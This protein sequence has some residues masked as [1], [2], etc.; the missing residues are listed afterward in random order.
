M[1]AL[2]LQ[3][4]FAAG[5]GLGVKA[6]SQRGHQVIVVG[7]LNYLFAALFGTLW[8]LGTPDVQAGWQGALFGGINGACYFTAYFFLIYAIRHQGLAATTAVGQLSIVLPI[9]ASIL[10]WSERPTPEQ[11]L[12]LAVAIPSLLL[13]DAQPGLLREITRQLRWRLLGFF[14]MVGTV[15]LVAK[16]FAEA[17]VPAQKVFYVWTVYAVAGLLSIPLLLRMGIRP[18]RAELGWGA[19]VGACNALQMFFLLTALEQLPGILV[20]PISAC[21]TLLV[22]ATVTV[23]LMGERPTRRIYAGLAL[24]VVAVLLLNRNG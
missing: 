13:L 17:A 18:R 21:G 10:L 16:A 11:W 7:G 22:T 8:L 2:V 9:L 19:F 3:F 6:A 24:S 23:G 4:L 14:T 15:R 5:F 20:F 12:G 1:W